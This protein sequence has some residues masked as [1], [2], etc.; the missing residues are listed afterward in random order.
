MGYFTATIEIKS[1]IAVGKF[2]VVKGNCGTL[3]GYQS[4]VDLGIIPVINRLS[5]DVNEIWE[6]FADLFQGIGKMKDVKVKI[7][8]DILFSLTD[9]NL[10]L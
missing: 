3:L 10:S 2:Y 8:I 6:E 1:K 5:T 4:A 9:G 7:H